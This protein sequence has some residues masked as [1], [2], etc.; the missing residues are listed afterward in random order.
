VLDPTKH[1]ELRAVIEHEGG[2]SFPLKEEQMIATTHQWTR[3]DLRPT[4][5]GLKRLN[6]NCWTR[7]KNHFPKNMKK[8]PGKRVRESPLGAWGGGGKRSRPQFNGWKTLQLPR[9]AFCPERSSTSTLR[10]FEKLTKRATSHS[11]DVTFRK[12]L[13]V[14]CNHSSLRILQGS[15]DS[16]RGQGW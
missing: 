3:T 16:Q 7:G 11:G 15:V 6:A 8:A 13:D 4:T 9:S 10:G 14:F 2:N 5:Q 1:S 12:K